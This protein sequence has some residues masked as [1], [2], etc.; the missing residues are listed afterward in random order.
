MEFVDTRALSKVS[1]KTSRD[2]RGSFQKPR[3]TPAQCST[4]NGD[5]C[6]IS[7]FRVAV[8]VEDIQ[9]PVS[10]IIRVCIQ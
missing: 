6:F 7:P 8:A 5:C 10:N 3:I 4:M 9:F 1:N 2:T